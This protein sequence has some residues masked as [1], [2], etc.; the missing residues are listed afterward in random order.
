MTDLDY[1]VLLKVLIIGDSAVGK[2]SIMSRYA[3]SS[4]T[5]SYISTIGVDFKIRTTDHNDKKI[6]L[7]IWDTAGQERFRTIVSSYYRSSHAIL[8]VYDITDRTSFN[9]IGFWLNEVKRYTTNNGADCAIIIVGNKVDLSVKRMV[10]ENEGKELADKLGY[11]YMEV[12]AKKNY[13][14][15]KVFI[16]LMDEAKF[17]LPNI[18]GGEKKKGEEKKEGSNL[19]IKGENIINER[20]Y[21]C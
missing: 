10:S 9:N 14:I 12:S 16:A 11:K 17:V 7:Q 21:C 5:D 6:K 18:F 13:N 8:V 2:S 19:N 3:D 1:D 4:Y 15:D 20:R